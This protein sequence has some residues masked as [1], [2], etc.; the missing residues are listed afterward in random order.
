MLEP[1]VG[2]HFSKSCVSRGTSDGIRI[3]QNSKTWRLWMPF[4]SLSLVGLLNSVDKAFGFFIAYLICGVS[5]F[6]LQPI[7]GNIWCWLYTAFSLRIW[8][9]AS[10]QVG[11]LLYRL[12]GKLLNIKFHSLEA[13]N[14]VVSGLYPSAP[15][16]PLVIGCDSSL[17]SAIDPPVCS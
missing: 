9:Y 3:L 17:Q 15:R 2:N 5:F 8:L 1:A 7:V 14:M 13:T 4:H 6:L 10:D 11:L 12:T 16:P